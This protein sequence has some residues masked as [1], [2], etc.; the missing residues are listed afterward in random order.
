[1]NWNWSHLKSDGLLAHTMRS[2]KLSGLLLLSGLAMVVHM[3]LPFWQQPK[4]LQ[5]GEVV[6]RIEELLE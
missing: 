1:M 6:R 5:G 3:L 2:A 4:F